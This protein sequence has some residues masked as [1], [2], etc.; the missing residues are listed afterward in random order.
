[1][2]VNSSAHYGHFSENGREYII[3]DPLAPPRAQ[4]NFLWNDSLISGVNQFGGGDG[5]FN[6]QTLLYNHPKGR[7]RMIRD[8]RRYFYL[9]DN[10][11][12]RFGTPACFRP[13]RPRRS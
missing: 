4:I 10:D 7:V 1:M 3:T 8:G 9:R 11:T 12:G 2:T 5:V 13:T 6:N